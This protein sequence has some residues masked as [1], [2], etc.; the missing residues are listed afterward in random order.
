MIQGMDCN[1]SP[2]CKPTT[3]IG[4]SHWRE[5][6]TLHVSCC[7]KSA[8][9]LEAAPTAIRNRITK[10]PSALL[11]RHEYLVLQQTKPVA[12]TPTTRQTTKHHLFPVMRSYKVESQGSSFC[13]HSEA[14]QKTHI[15]I[16]ILETSHQLP[17]PQNPAQEGNS[18]HIFSIVFCVCISTI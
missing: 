3:A 4:H 18:D 5:S 1:G 2:A 10:T 12:P 11:T 6:Q 8:A 13:T 15:T 7:M 9:R 16:S 14:P 17:K